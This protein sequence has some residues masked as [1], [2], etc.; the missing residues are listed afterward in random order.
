[1]QFRFISRPGHQ[2][3]TSGGEFTN[4]RNRP[5]VI[6]VAI[7]KGVVLVTGSDKNELGKWLLGMTPAEASDLHLVAGYRPM[8]RR[9]GLLRSAHDTALSG[10][11]IEAMLRAVL[12][13]YQPELSFDGTDLDCSL[14]IRDGDVLHR[15]RLNVFRAGGNVGACFRAIPEDVPNFEW[16]GIPESLVQ[17]LVSFRNGLVII[18][19]ITGSGKTTTL[20]GLIEWINQNQSRR[21]VTIEQPVEYVFKSNGTSVVSQREVGT[22]VASFY[23]GLVHGLRQDPDVMLIGEIRDPETARMALSAAETGHLIF[24]TLHT[25]DAKGAITRLVDFF[26]R[27][28][29]DD[30]RTQLSLSLRSV[31]GQHLLPAAME[32]ERRALAVEV[33]HVTYGVRSAIRQ[34]KIESIDTA[35]QTGKKEGMIPLDES[36]ARLASAGRISWETAQKFANDAQ[37]L[38]R[39]VG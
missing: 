26:P 21:I 33:L 28:A 39:Y 34:G 29:Q 5:T 20:A 36:L 15:F 24:A 17:K 2:R 35:I 22:D 8:Y 9:H 19:G 30:V 32:G 14:A 18:T 16:M 3:S 10:G 27:D 23:D 38:R 6:A 13:D 4:D 31:V 25:Q 11:A 7:L 12:A 37:G 1:M